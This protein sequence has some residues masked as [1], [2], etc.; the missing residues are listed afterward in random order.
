M[1]ALLFVLAVAGCAGRRSATSETP[2]KDRFVT[3]DTY[4][5]D[6]VHFCPNPA[7]VITSS[8]YQFKLWNAR[9]GALLDAL[10]V[11]SNNFNPHRFS[12]SPDGHHIAV[13][14]SEIAVYAVESSR[15]VRVSRAALGT[16]APPPKVSH[17][18]RT[19][20]L[21][22]EL[23]TPR[24]AALEFS[25]AGDTLLSALEGSTK[26]D[27]WDPKTLTRLG[28]FEVR[29]PAV[30]EVAFAGDGKYLAILTEAGVRVMERG[31]SP[32]SWQLLDAVDALAGIKGFLVQP[33]ST[34]ILA[35]DEA[36]RMR[37]LGLPDGQLIAALDLP[38][39]FPT[40]TRDGGYMA[41]STGAGATVYRLPDLAVLKHLHYQT[42]QEAETDKGH[43][44]LLRLEGRRLAYSKHGLVTIWDVETDTRVVNLLDVRPGFH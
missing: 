34:S 44:L 41:L 43:P 31:S 1:H 6:S 11:E 20:V 5:V 27:L 30:E 10:E 25:P 21:D 23:H 8:G 36:R 13:G 9:T 7:F 42:G 15:F 18:P 28:S 24:L 39:E 17:D 40:F 12:C 26:I 2:R 38:G 32:L 16:D 37:L 33:G 22:I 14:I 3:H 19:G 4:S 35:F 29:V